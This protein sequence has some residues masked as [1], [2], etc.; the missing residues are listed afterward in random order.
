MT[1]ALNSLPYADKWGPIVIA[2]IILIVGMFLAK[3]IRGF[4]RKSLSRVSALNRVN[5][6]GSVTDLATP[7]SMLV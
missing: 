1:D 7:I 2:L 6:D 3:L 4:V 5:P